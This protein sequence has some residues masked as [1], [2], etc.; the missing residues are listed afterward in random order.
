MICSA[1]AVQAI[2]AANMNIASSEMIFIVAIQERAK[3]YLVLERM[4]TLRGAVSGNRN[5]NIGVSTLYIKLQR[6]LHHHDLC[7]ELE[8]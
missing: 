1:I 5:N 4:P 3:T 8:R 7:F 2:T 6:C